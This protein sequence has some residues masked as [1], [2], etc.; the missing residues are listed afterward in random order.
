MLDLVKWS[1]TLP[2]IAIVL[3]LGARLAS[4]GFQ[5]ILKKISDWFS[6]DRPREVF[7]RHS[8]TKS[9]D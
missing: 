8:C 6:E 5:F 1:F 2:M 9:L 4:N 7:T 3:A